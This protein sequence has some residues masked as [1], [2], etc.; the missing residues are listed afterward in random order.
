MN[1]LMFLI[2]EEFN[3]IDINRLKNNLIQTKPPK[4]KTG[5]TYD[6]VKML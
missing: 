4:G 1:D 3:R 5:T 6:P 2:E